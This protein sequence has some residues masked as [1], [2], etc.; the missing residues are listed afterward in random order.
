MILLFVSVWIRPSFGLQ[1]P[2]TVTDV[3]PAGK[4]EIEFPLEGFAERIGGEL[5]EEGAE[6]RTIGELVG[7][8]AAAF[9]DLRV[10]AVD[11]G[12]RGG[13]TKPGMTRYWNERLWSAASAS[14]ASRSRERSAIEQEIQRRRKS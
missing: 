9:G 4:I 5:V 7:G 12:E 1:R 3:R 13:R 11:F 6:R 2:R 10:V 8:E 14:S